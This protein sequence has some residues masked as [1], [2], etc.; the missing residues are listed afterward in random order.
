MVAVLEARMKWIL[1]KVKLTWKK[2]ILKR[3]KLTWNLEYIWL[4]ILIVFTL[5]LLVVTFDHKEDFIA[6]VVSFLSTMMGVGA[7]GLITFHL[8]DKEVKRRKD[9]N[10]LWYY[11]SILDTSFIIAAIINS[12]NGGGFKLLRFK[13]KYPFDQYQKKLIIAKMAERSLNHGVYIGKMLKELRGSL[14][15]MNQR[16]TFRMIIMQW[17]ILRGFDEMNDLS[18]STLNDLYPVFMEL[19]NDVL[20]PALKDLDDIEIRNAIFACKESSKAFVMMYNYNK[21][22]LG[23]EFNQNILS[24]FAN[25]INLY[26]L[27]NKKLNLISVDVEVTYEDKVGIKSLK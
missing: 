8:V 1:N 17:G 3:G 15:Y 20:N 9:L 24:F 10:M 5:L 4:L 13:D 18:R 21:V 2:L 11:K 19:I 14:R 23:L 7:G 12:Y 26:E 22:K 27:I 25:F 6:G 16:M